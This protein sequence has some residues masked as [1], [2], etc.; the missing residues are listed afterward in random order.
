M[1]CKKCKKEIPEGSLYC[2]HCGAPQKRDKKKK[3]YQRPDGLYEI[4]KTIRGKRV[5]F[6]GKTEKEVLDK[7][8][9]YTQKEESGPTFKE[10]SERWEIEYLPKL[11]WNT[12]RGYTAPLKN[13][14]GYFSDDRIREIKPPQL[15]K[16]AAS[17]A[18]K[19][20]A[21]KTIRN[22]LA[23][24]G[25]IFRFAVLEGIV[26]SSPVSDI[27]VTK[28]KPSQKRKPATKEDIKAV[29]SN[30]DDLMGILLMAFLFTGMR[31]GEALA[32]RGKDILEGKIQITRSV[33]DYHNHSKE[34]NPKTESGTRVI[35]LP[36]ILSKILPKV[37]PEEFVFSPH[38]ET[39]MKKSEYDSLMRKYRK[40]YGITS[41]AHQFRHSYASLLFDAGFL[42]KEAQPQ[43]G[44]S[45]IVVTEDIYTH[46]SDDHLEENRKKLDAYIASSYS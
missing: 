14:S 34:K 43:L 29:L 20:Y 13:V 21:K 12:Q 19:G 33:Y 2:N 7:M 36:E 38:P 10:V 28:G 27:Q 44:H 24:V 40:K 4:H 11:A 8:L 18:A 15:M 23:V 17:L 6:R 25:S 32:L 3:M 9:A 30:H 37:K 16:Y 39:P 35:I 31:W 42:P 45:S 1:L 22:Y 41:T 5:Y 26:E 46:L